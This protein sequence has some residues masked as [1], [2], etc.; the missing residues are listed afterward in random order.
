MTALTTMIVML[1]IAFGAGAGLMMA[2]PM[3]P[4]NPILGVELA[5]EIEAVAKQ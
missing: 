2:G 5:R 1:L 4:N 3:K